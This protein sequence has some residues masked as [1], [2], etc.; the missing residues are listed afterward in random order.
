MGY[1]LWRAHPKLREELAAHPLGSTGDH[2]V[3]IIPPES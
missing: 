1:Y 2:E 3:V